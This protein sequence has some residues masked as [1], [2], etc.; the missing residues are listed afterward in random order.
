MEPTGEGSRSIDADEELQNWADNVDE[1]GGGG[2]DGLDQAH[3][4]GAANQ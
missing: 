3:L 4:G 2:G 1:A